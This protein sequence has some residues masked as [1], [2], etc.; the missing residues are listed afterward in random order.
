MHGENNMKETESVYCAVQN[1]S[2]CCPWRVN[3]HWNGYTVDG[4]RRE[5]ICVQLCVWLQ[6]S[7]KS[8]GNLR[9]SVCFP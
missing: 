9:L 7:C 8:W 6:K 3:E 4:K 1:G 2:M 5:V